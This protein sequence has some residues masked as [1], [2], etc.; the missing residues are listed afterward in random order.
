MYYLVALE[1]S[2]GTLMGAYKPLSRSGRP[3][4]HPPTIHSFI[5]PFKIVKCS[6][7][8]SMKGNGPKREDTYRRSPREAIL[9]D[10]DRLESG[11]GLKTVPELLGKK[12]GT[13]PTRTP[14][15]L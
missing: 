4:P 12:I 13:L 15:I 1:P 9:G 10:S 14:K 2:D 5:C 11:G 6:A 8:G 3:R 7:S